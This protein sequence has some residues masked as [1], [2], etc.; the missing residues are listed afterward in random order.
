MQSAAYLKNKISLFNT[1][2]AEYMVAFEFPYR[3]TQGN[4]IP[5][6]AHPGRCGS[7][8]QMGAFTNSNGFSPRLFGKPLFVAYFT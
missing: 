6:D 5:G 1:S 3:R 4:I 2:A 7:I 8:L